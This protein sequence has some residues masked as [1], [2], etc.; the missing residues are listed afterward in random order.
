MTRK[1]LKET[2]VWLRITRKVYAHLGAGTLAA[3]WEFAHL[4]ERE[5][6]FAV[7]MYALGQYVIQTVCD[8]C[9]KKEIDY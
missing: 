7:A 9:F 5:M 3:I 8:V 6:L 1:K 4:T 2:P